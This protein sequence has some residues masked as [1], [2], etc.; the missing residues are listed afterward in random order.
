MR[1]STLRNT[2]AAVKPAWVILA[3]ACLAIAGCDDRPKRVSVEGVVLIDGK[4][5][6]KG[7]LVFVPE[8]GRPSSARIGPDGR[9]VL[10]CFEKD[11]GALLGTHRVAVSAKDIISENNI[12]W[13]APPKYSDYRTSGITVEITEAVEDLVIEL[14]WAGESQ[15]VRGR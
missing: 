11:D 14:T 7:N 8:G 9:F 5:V 3:A 12:K 1:K 4:P 10:R 2:A 6:E 15:S 13:Y